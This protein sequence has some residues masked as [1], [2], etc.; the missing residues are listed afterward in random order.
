MMKCW[1]SSVSSNNYL[2]LFCTNS[3]QCLYSHDFWDLDSL[4]RSLILT[5]K[6]KFS[7]FNKAYCERTFPAFKKALPSVKKGVSLVLKGRG[8]E[9]FSGGSAPCPLSFTCPPHFLAAGAA[10]VPNNKQ[11]YQVSWRIRKE[12]SRGTQFTAS[13]SG[14]VRA[15]PR[16]IR[17]GQAPQPQMDKI[18]WV[19]F[20]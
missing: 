18:S 3:Y 19:F 16:E 4:V 15:T 2:V 10:T 11:F 14:M 13:K 7:N 8:P 6:R 1:T 12:Q 9:K 17:K 20:L 5:G